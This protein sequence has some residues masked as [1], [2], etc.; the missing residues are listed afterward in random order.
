MPL[1]P[2][3]TLTATLL[4]FSGNEI[5]SATYPAYLRIKLCGYGQTVPCVPGVGMIGKV[6]SDPVNVAYEGAQI[7]VILWGND[8]ISPNGTYYE[9]AVLDTLGN[10]VQSG[11]YQFSGTETIDLSNAGQIVQPVLNP[12][13]AGLQAFSST[14]IASGF[15]Y[16]LPYTPRVATPL[17][18]FR[19]GL[20]ITQGIDF[21]LSGTTVTFTELLEDGDVVSG[22]LWT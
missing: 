6:A 16:V 5:G 22:L 1:T 11:I 2:Q 12:P 21:S 15:T 13:I 8:V 9:I 17:F 3:I 19:G 14:I 18:L 7:S 4:D 10:V 20:F